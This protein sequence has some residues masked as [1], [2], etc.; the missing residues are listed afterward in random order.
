M[1]SNIKLICFLFLLA[2]GLSS[3]FVKR[4]HSEKG[5][6]WV[7]T[8]FASDK[9]M[10]YFVK[11]ILFQESESNKLIADFSFKYKDEWKDSAIM[12]FTF[13]SNMPIKSLDSI[14]ITA[15]DR[16]TTFPISSHLFS[17]KYHNSIANRFSVSIPQTYFKKMIDASTIS[18]NLYY[19]SKVEQY[20]SSDKAVKAFNYLSKNIL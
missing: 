15:K 14:K 5:H 8:F 11:P 6:K 10:L 19:P 18:I 7:E 12:N 17:E 9:G 16:V 13:Y 20:K 1:K 4:F 2:L 3:C